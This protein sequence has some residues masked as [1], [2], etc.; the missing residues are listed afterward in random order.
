MSS[1]QTLICCL[2]LLV[3][4]IEKTEHKT[5]NNILTYVVFSIRDDKRLKASNAC[6]FLKFGSQ[7]KGEREREGGSEGGRGRERE[8]GRERVGREGGRR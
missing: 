2:W 6:V 8:R 5:R 4:L 1:F 7:R 3:R